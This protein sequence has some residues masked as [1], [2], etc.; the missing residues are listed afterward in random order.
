MGRRRYQVI[1]A[2][3]TAAVMALVVFSGEGIDAYYRSRLVEMVR[4]TAYRPYVYRV[5]VPGA[6]RV[7]TLLTPAGTRSMLVGAFRAW[8]WRPDG[9]DPDHAPEYASV[10]LLMT[11]SLVGFVGA[12]RA[13]FDVVFADNSKGAATTLTALAVLPIFFGPFSRQIYDFT[14]LW[15]FTLGLTFIADARWRRFAVL[16]PIAC[17]N[18]ETAI[19]LTLVFCVYGLRHRS[20]AVPFRLLLTYQL[21]VFG[22]IRIALLYAFRNNPGSPVEVH[23]FDHNLQV[24]LHPWWVSKRFVIA[25]LATGVGVVG[26]KH[27]PTFL[28]DAALS[29]IPVLGLMGV[30]V[31]QV[32]EIRAYYEIYPVV[33]LL[34]ADTVFSLSG[35]PLTPI[36]D[37]R[38]HPLPVPRAVAAS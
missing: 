2:V 30:T 36:L 20:A 16:F 25:V 21:I 15:L 6:A 8:S 37:K 13:M 9:W 27:K 33:I 23:L 5:L 7:A 14:T 11:I 29:L 26:W 1:V 28:R 31:G 22:V 24:F 35:A 19:L 18:K 4:G 32:D 38:R 10:L 34:V 12:M 3:I 17:L